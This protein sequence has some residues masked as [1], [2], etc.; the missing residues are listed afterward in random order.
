MD[1]VNTTDKIGNTKIASFKTQDNESFD[2]SYLFDLNQL[3]NTQSTKNPAYRIRYGVLLF[4]CDANV[5]VFLPWNIYNVLTCRN[6]HFSK[7]NALVLYLQ[8]IPGPRSLLLGVLPVIVMAGG[9]AMTGAAMTGVAMIGI[10]LT[11][12]SA[13]LVV[14]VMMQKDKT[15]VV[16]MYALSSWVLS[17]SLPSSFTSGSCSSI[18]GVM[19]RRVGLMVLISVDVISKESIMIKGRVGL[20]VLI[21]V[22]ISKKNIIIDCCVVVLIR[23]I[24]IFETS[25]SGP[26]RGLSW[27]TLNSETFPFWIVKAKALVTFL[28]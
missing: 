12:T 18:L 16:M 27:E 1:L 11:N 26:P 10:A 25:A 20:M 3:S 22:V 28:K 24:L 9:V 19:A 7:C 21:L 23:C 15:V 2:G 5:A 13:A 4:D 6:Q 14:V 17:P 8:I